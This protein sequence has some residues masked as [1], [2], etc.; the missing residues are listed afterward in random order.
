MKV[1]RLTCLLR[2]G[3]Q[4]VRV[5]YPGAEDTPDAFFLRCLR[6]GTED[7]KTRSIVPPPSW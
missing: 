6:C 3:H 1:K 4:W 2:G 5:R 7:R